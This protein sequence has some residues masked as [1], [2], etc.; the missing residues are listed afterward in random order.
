VRPRSIERSRRSH[1][2]SPRSELAVISEGV[3]QGQPVTRVLNTDGGFTLLDAEMADENPDEHYLEEFHV[4]CVDCLLEG[5]PE[6]GRGMDLARRAGSS[7]FHAGV[8]ME[9]IA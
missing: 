5:H 1:H 9:E 3:H 8:W 7:R 4:V 2:F 6:A